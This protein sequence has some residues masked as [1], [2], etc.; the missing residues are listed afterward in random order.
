MEYHRWISF[1]CSKFEWHSVIPFFF[2]RLTLKKQNIKYFVYS[3]FLSAIG[4]S[5][6]IELFE[7]QKYNTIKDLEEL[8]WEDF[9]D[10]GVK[11]LGHMKRLG[12][13]LKKLKTN[14]DARQKQK[15][16]AM[17][18]QQSSSS[19]TSYQASDYPTATLTSRSSTALGDNGSFDS[20]CNTLRKPSRMSM[21]EQ[22]PRPIAPVFPSHHV[23]SSSENIKLSSKDIEKPAEECDDSP[24]EK[25]QKE[26]HFVLETRKPTKL[27]LIT[28]DQI[29]SKLDDIENGDALSMSIADDIPPSPAPISCNTALEKF[30][31]M[32]NQSEFSKRH[33][34]NYE[35]YQ[36]NYQFINGSNGLPVT[37]HLRYHHNEEPYINDIEHLN[38]LGQM[39][40]DLTD[41]L[42]AKLNPCGSTAV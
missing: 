25:Q 5:Q 4:L 7:S 36:G 22:R 11:K 34:N 16:D 37:S 21:P 19:Q 1:I 12:I 13:A 10:V 8:S 38:D 15:S 20:T 9:E 29:L 17:T 41:E 28:K 39:L 30:Y 3:D 23:S 24:I 40:R 32:K 2:F 27:N 14:R 42:D 26:Y 35:S 33:R 18:N 6:Y 31:A